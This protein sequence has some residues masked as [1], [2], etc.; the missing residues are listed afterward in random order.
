MWSR[1][2]GKAHANG[3]KLVTSARPCPISSSLV[4]ESFFS[5]AGD[6]DSQQWVRTPALT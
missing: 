5:A 4:S 1:K 2:R 3:D 6:S